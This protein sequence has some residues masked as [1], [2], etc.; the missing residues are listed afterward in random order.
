MIVYFALIDNSQIKIGSTGGS[1]SRRLNQFRKTTLA[2]HDVRLL[3]AVHGTKTDENAVQRYFY[4]DSVVELRPPMSKAPEVFEVTSRLTE[5]IRWLR[6]QWFV[7][8]DEKEAIEDAVTSEAWLPNAQRCVSPPK[9]RPLFDADLLDFS[10]REITA[11]DYYTPQEVI[12]CTR[13]L[14]GKIDLDPASHAFANR[15]V[16]AARFFSVNDNGLEQPWEGRIWCNPPFSKYRDWVPKIIKELGSKRVIELCFF[17]SMHATTAYYFSRVL[18]IAQA[19]CI[20]RGRL[21][22]GGIGEGKSPDRGHGVFYIGPQ[23]ELFL[24][25]FSRIGSVWKKQ[26]QVLEDQDG[27]Q[28]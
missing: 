17:A 19:L 11:D 1:L 6:N 15:R 3:A 23:V 21:P 9:I 16:K 14:F 13:E 5:Y 4:G 27:T 20:I 22:H 25:V 2:V 28:S 26:H 18:D 12:D 8:V 24:S 7:I 10:E